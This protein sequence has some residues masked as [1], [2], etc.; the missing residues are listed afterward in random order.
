M[1]GLSNDS[2]GGITSV[3]NIYREA[4]LFD[5]LPITYLTSYQDGDKL[6]KLLVAISCLARYVT[7]LLFSRVAVV[8]IHVAT[9][10]SFWRKSVFI[11]LARARRLPVIFHLHGAEFMQFYAKDCR[12]FARWFIRNVLDHVDKIIVLSSQWKDQISS[13][14][15]NPNLLCIFNPV[16]VIASATSVARREDFTILFLGRLGKRKGIYDL[17]EALKK[18]RLNY[19]NVKLLCGGDGEIEKAK[20]YARQLAISE[21]VEILGWVA[22]LE[23]QSLLDR[24]TLYVLPSYNEGLPMGILEAMSNGLP[25]VASTV[26]GIPDAVENGVEGI[27]VNPGDIEGLTSAILLLLQDGALR[28]RMAAAGRKKIE[29]F[30]TPE[31]ILPQLESLYREYGVAP[32]CE[33]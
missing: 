9:H 2:K 20:D 23:K 1:I 16:H 13:I 3:V 26:G 22:G 8:H 14:T 11:L 10:A 7:L 31:R 4:G 25:V 29:M 30:F 6:H 12:T 32:I 24:A 15:R 5:R 21:S 19:P 17:L 18:V 27:L 28:E 33:N